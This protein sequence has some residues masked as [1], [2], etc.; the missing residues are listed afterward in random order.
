MSLNGYLS[1][2]Y[3]PELFQFLEK[4]KKTGWLRI[5]ALPRVSGYRR[6]VHHFWVY[7]GRIVA[8]A[9]RLDHQGLI[10]LIAQHQWLKHSIVT[11]L[12]QSCT[13]NQPLGLY[14]QTQGILQTAQLKWL[15]QIQI[16][17][18]V[19]PLFELKD[20]R[21]KF[22]QNVP[23]PTL[24]MTG[25]S[26]PATEATLIGLRE[27]HDWEALAE[28]LPDPDWGL[29]STICDPPQSHYRLNVLECKV[30]N[31]T[32]GKVSLKAIAKHL[33]LPVAQVRQIAFRLITVGLAQAKPLLKDTSHKHLDKC[34]Q[35]Q[36]ALDKQKY[37]F[38]SFRCNSS[39]V[40]KQ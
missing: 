37:P 11:T 39:H 20:G 24:E 25:L 34:I 5:T 23:I 6:P 21:F 32:T 30:W 15:F 1:D 16:Q 8:A 10:V 14:L 26:I 31:Y 2:L 33:K 3:L 12:A 36:I 7:Q 29:V 27:L 13:P 4:G 17:R 22:E 9:N 40:R 18:Q 35:N 38:I 28:Q 19:C